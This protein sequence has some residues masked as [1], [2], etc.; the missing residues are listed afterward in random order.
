MKYL[1]WPVRATRVTALA[2]IGA[3]FDHSRRFAL[4]PARRR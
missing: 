3:P 2:T 4:R 1:W